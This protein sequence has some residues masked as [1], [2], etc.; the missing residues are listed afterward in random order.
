MG[1][2]W[3]RH[4][5]GPEVDPEEAMKV[6]VVSKSMF[7]FKV[8]CGKSSY[9]LV[10]KAV[11]KNTKVEYAIKVMDKA[12]VYNL[13]SIDCILNELKL[14]S[15]LRSPFIVNIHYAFHERS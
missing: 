3:S 10:W 9:G 13:R 11:K 1:K 8:A 12:G 14:L 15:V 7:A 5:V 2:C 4:A 6:L